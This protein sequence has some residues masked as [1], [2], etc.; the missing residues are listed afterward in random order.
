MSRFYVPSQDLVD[1]GLKV[2]YGYDAVE[3][4]FFCA[5]YDKDET[6][7]L[8]LYC[9]DLREPSDLEFAL[10]KYATIRPFKILQLTRERAEIKN[11]HSELLRFLNEAS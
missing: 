1:S 4:I 8:L 10:R 2:A 7:R 6:G 11:T 3:D 5:V 9:D